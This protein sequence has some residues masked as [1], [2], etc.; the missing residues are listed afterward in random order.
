MIDVEK[1]IISQYA[2]SPTILALISNMN[3]YIDPTADIDNFF[4]LVFNVDTSVGFGLD[5]WGRIV[6]IDRNVLTNPIFTLDDDVYR[7]LIL[8]KALSNISTSDSPSINQLLKNWTSTFPGQD[9]ANP[10]RAYVSDLGK[11]NLR[12]NFEFTL[13]PYQSLIIQNSGIFLRPAGVD[14]S[15]ISTRLPMFGFREGG[16]RAYTGFN[17]APFVSETNI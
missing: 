3:D 16:T 6:D 11:M 4:N 13:E 1:T 7:S 12:Y 15:I 17:Q 8:L 2:N 14:A 9:P 10:P 5:I